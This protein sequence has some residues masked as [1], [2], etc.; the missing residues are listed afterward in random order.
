M[1]SKL[2]FSVSSFPIVQSA[3]RTDQE[4]AWDL[5]I[6]CEQ[7]IK[8]QE[9][10][11]YGVKYHS[12]CVRCSSCDIQINNDSIFTRDAKLFCSK[13]IHVA[14]NTEKTK[15]CGHCKEEIT[16]DDIFLQL[17]V[18]NEAKDGE[19]PGFS[20]VLL[21]E[22]CL[23]CFGCK[24]HIDYTGTFFDR[25]QQFY[26]KSC[27]ISAFTTQCLNCKQPINECHVSVE[28]RTYHPQCF[29]C[30]EKSCG[31]KLTGTF[32]TN[33]GMPYCVECYYFYFAKKCSKC[34]TAINLDPDTGRST[35]ISFNKKFFHQNCFRCEQP[36]CDAVIDNTL[37]SLVDKKTTCQ[38]CAKN[39]VVA[40]Q[41]NAVQTSS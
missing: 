39:F 6:R 19:M 31:K 20:N 24:E 30:S 33:N 1:T 21:H 25:N 41:T 26:C 40:L 8:E 23:K 22:T 36:K 29:K 37:F 12:E 18:K 17:P 3:G 38:N 28:D 9:V 16:T 13:C 7:P 32:Q 14:G 11:L 27:Y 10:T 5:C 34:N 35:F 4:Y 15:S 2:S